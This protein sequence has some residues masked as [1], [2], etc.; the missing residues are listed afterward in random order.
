MTNIWIWIEYDYSLIYT[1]KKIKK[2]HENAHIPWGNTHLQMCLCTFIKTKIKTYQNSI[3]SES[4]SD[5]T[6]GFLRRENFIRWPEEGTICDHPLTYCWWL[7]SYTTWDV[8]NLVNHGINNLSTGAGFQPST[9]VSISISQ[10]LVQHFSHR[11]MSFSKSEGY[12]C[13]QRWSSSQLVGQTSFW[14][15]V[16]QR[17]KT[18]AFQSCQIVLS[19]DCQISS[20]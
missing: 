7:K 5:K 16:L 4:M 6:H 20:P 10:C 13:S 11:W 8:L 14:V 3:L 15:E 18:T 17:D 2:W 1:Y 9:V 12:L 19:I